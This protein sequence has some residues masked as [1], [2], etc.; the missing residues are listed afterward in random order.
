MSN[1]HVNVRTDKMVA[2][3]VSPKKG[4]VYTP[5]SVKEMNV[6]SSDKIH[7]IQYGIE[8]MRFTFCDGLYQKKKS[9][10]KGVVNYKILLKLLLKIRILV[11]SFL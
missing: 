7:I 6:Q 4:F 1:Q 10:Y 11:K 2:S 3:S 8:N 5:N 9:T